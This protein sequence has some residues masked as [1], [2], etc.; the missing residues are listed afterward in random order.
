MPQTALAKALTKGD[1]SAWFDLLKPIYLSLS[2]APFA[3]LSLLGIIY[4]LRKRPDLYLLLAWVFGYISFVSTFGSWWPWYKPSV[5]VFYSISIGVGLNWIFLTME[6]RISERYAFTFIALIGVS[7]FLGALFKTIS[8]LQ[9]IS[10][11][12]DTI[13][14]TVNSD[15]F[16]KKS[17]IEIVAD[18]VILNVHQDQVIMLEPLGLF[19]YNVPHK[20]YDYPGLASRQVTDALKKIAPPRGGSPADVRTFSFVL[21]EVKPSVLILRDSEWVALKNAEK[22]TMYEEKY[23]CCREMEHIERQGPYHVLFRLNKAQ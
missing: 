4:I 16:H 9:L 19:G 18:W 8:A 1:R 3:V 12:L 14:T 7:I 15:K 21:E 6:K 5:M 11:N 10:P 2:T 23:E 13:F 22:L 17:Q 20:I